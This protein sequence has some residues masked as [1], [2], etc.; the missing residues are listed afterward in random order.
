MKRRNISLCLIIFL[1]GI[2]GILAYGVL[3]GRTR[4]EETHLLIP[5]P[6][7]K[8][9]SSE[10][11]LAVLSDI[12]AMPWDGSYIDRI[13]RTVLE[14]EADAVLLL[15]DYLNGRPGRPAMKVETL[16]KHLRPLTALPCFA[17]LGNHDYYHGSLQ[18]RR[19]FSR[20]GIPLMERRREDVQ[21]RGQEISFGGV[22]CLCTFRTPGYI[23]PPVPGKPYILLSHTPRGTD[24]APPGT[25]ITLAGH[26][27]GGQVCFPGGKSIIKPDDYT[28]RWRA[29]GLHRIGKQW[30]YVT[31]GLGTSILPIRLFCRPELLWVTLRPGNTEPVTCY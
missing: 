18:F 14:G 23:E 25:L 3:V 27:H 20:L 16:E 22:R 17:V 19:M 26:T 11:K 30:E 9:G 28:P 8:S 31:R 2:L 29:A 4:M 5:V 6:Q 13:V 12:H 21:L 24:V 15:G 7:W 10:V 1:L